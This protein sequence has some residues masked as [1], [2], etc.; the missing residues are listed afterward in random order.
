MRINRSE[1]QINYPRQIENPSLKPEQCLPMLLFLTSVPGC[2]Q[3]RARGR[4][5]NCYRADKI[6][7][8][9]F[10]RRTRATIDHR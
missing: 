5:Y 4:K 3:N 8:L 6:G 2:T 7:R 10:G 9:E 1:K